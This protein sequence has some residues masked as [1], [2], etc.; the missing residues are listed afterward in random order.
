[1][2]DG[3][4]LLIESV[5]GRLAW[6]LMASGGRVLNA[7]GRCARI[8]VYFLPKVK[9]HVVLDR[10]RSLGVHSKHP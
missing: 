6:R 10:K 4:L 9:R 7:P 5:I 1:M 2:P 3:F 8:M